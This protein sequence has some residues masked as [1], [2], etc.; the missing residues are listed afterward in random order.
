MVWRGLACDYER[1]WL[2]SGKNNPSYLMVDYMS[3]TL[4]SEVFDWSSSLVIVNIRSS[5][6]IFSWASTLF[7]FL[8]ISEG[9]LS[10]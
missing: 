7:Y 6:F 10:I 3:E 4:Y 2:T 8:K 9:I 5:G 1:L